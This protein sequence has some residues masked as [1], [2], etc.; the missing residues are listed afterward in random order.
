VTT[1]LTAARVGA[2]ERDT[3]RI[4][5]VTHRGIADAEVELAAELVA[6][7]VAEHAH[8]L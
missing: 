3:S 8:S 5:L 1:Q 2:L 4:R 7:V 6:A